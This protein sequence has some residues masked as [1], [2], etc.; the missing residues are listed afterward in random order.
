MQRRL[1]IKLL[2]AVMGTAIAVAAGTGGAWAQGKTIRVG[3]MSGSD[4][5]IWEVVQKVAKQRGLDIKIIEFSDYARPNEALNSGDLDANGFQ[6]RPFLDSQIHDRGYKLVSAGLTY[7][8]PMGFYSK[9]VKSLKDLPQGAKV[10]IQNDP[11]NGSRALL[12]LQK[13]G[14]I[15]LKAGVGVGGANATPLDVV[16]NPKKLK[17]VEL[18]AAQLPR[19]LPD[20]DAAA[21]NT[22]FAVQAGLSPKKD[23]IALEDLHG[24]YAN[25]IAV[26]TQDKDKPWVKQLVSAYQSPE[27]RQFIETQFKGALIPA[28]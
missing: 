12:L 17:L 19:A 18:D 10:G 14:L 27:V 13:E 2:T 26:R 1:W 21:I 8:S 22:N 6:H 15:K 7:V 23:A 16:S 20:L 5:Q 11:S 25:L 24:P 9:K 4:A 28:F 3:T